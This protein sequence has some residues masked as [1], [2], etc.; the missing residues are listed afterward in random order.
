MNEVQE[1]VADATKQD[2]LSSLERSQPVLQQ[3]VS[4]LAKYKRYLQSYYKAR[5][6]APADKYLPTLQVPY[7]NLAM[8]K[9]ER[10]DSDARDEFTR[11]TLHGGV[12]QILGSKTP[13]NIEDLLVPEEVSE[14]VKFVL[15]EG[16]PGIGKSTFAW[17][18]CRRWDEIE[19]LRKHHT[20]L[21]LSLREKWVLNA[22]KSSD[23]F[24]YPP[25]PDMSTSIAEDLNGSHGH[26]LLLVLDGFDEISHSFHE[27]SVIKSILCRELLTECTIIVTTRPSARHVLK[28][29]CQPEVDKHIEIVGFTEEERV[30]YITKV[31]RKE[32]E[33]QANFLKYMFHLPHI[34]S[35]VYIPLNCA[36]IAKVYHESQQSGNLLAIPRTRTQLYKALTHSLLLRH[37]KTMG[38]SFDYSCMLP[39]GLNQE[40]MKKFKVLAKFAFAS[41]HTKE[42]NHLPYSF[43]VLRDPN[44]IKQKVTFFEKDIPEGLVHFGF[45]NE[46]T[47]M[48]ASKEMEQT[49]SFL[50]LSLQEYLAAWHITNS[51]S[52]EFQMVYYTLAVEAIGRR[53]L[54]G[55]SRLGPDIIRQREPTL[56]AQSQRLAKSARVLI[57]SPIYEAKVLKAAYDE[58]TS[59]LQYSG[60][61]T[62]ANCEEEEEELISSL[63]LLRVLLNEPALFLAGITGFRSETGGNWECH[64]FKKQ[65]GIA[66]CTTLL[67]SLY[68]AQNPDILQYYN[69]IVDKEIRM[70]DVS[71]GTSG[72]ISKPYDCYA[73]SYCLAHLKSFF[74]I[75]LRI[76]RD[77]DVTLL[78]TFV[79]GLEDHWIPT[80]PSVFE[81]LEVILD[82]TISEEMSNKC[83]F[84]LTKAKF[85]SGVKSMTINFKKGIRS[86]LLYYFLIS[87]VKVQILDIH[88]NAVSWDWL[89]A[90]EHLNELRTLHACHFLTPFLK[91]PL[92]DIHDRNQVVFNLIN[93]PQFNICM[94]SLSDKTVDSL[95]KVVPRSSQLTEVDLPNVSRATMARVRSSILHCPNLVTLKLRETRLGYDGILYIC[96]ALRNNTSLKHLL[97][98]EHMQVPEW[99]DYKGD[100]QFTSFVSMERVALPDKTSCTDFLLEL[101][102]ILQDNSTVKNLQIMTEIFSHLHYIIRGYR[103]WT[104]LGPLQQF[105]ARAVTSGRFPNLRR[106]FST[107][108]LTQPQTLLFW[109][110]QQIQKGRAKNV[111]IDFKNF[112]SKRKAKGVRP[113]SLPS[114]TAPATTHV[115]EPFFSLDDRLIENCL[116]IPRFCEYGYD[117]IIQAVTC[118]FEEIS[119]HMTKTESSHAVQP[120]N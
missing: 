29:F 59:N 49:F 55:T 120:A 26:G 20:V 87:L 63:E 17:E 12:D 72:L 15:V 11:R 28:S 92:Y 61:T 96:S 86:D 94:N 22:K 118:L 112:F 79:K 108:D 77:D 2:V 7:I 37:V 53:Y 64:V 106:S 42:Q 38:S 99:R 41:Y 57:S 93:I 32:P 89:A 9:K 88:A 10:C 19:G 74:S 60:E 51:Y 8:I 68:E 30:R 114:F 25:D 83:I 13:I 76:M 35:M 54:R 78:E 117:I 44:I 1:K 4:P 100:L 62:L 3:D 82:Y 85:L 84:W 27:D 69:I 91:C 115:L 104:G 5:A 45:M 16:P 109:D 47:E 39:E 23:L 21:L 33:V 34:K 36:I 103:Q 52:T 116:H 90:L 97:I 95:L 73:L 67:H 18:L 24:R 75:S 50:H 80:K 58:K 31:F 119:E 66:N 65:I 56:A 110:Q 98:L 43:G 70:I 46:S 48:Y 6:L 107:S 102:N 101:N 40:D 71:I 81:H 113:F 111:K 14:S 105:N